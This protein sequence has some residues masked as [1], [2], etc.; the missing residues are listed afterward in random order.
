MS[1]YCDA[2]DANVKTAVISDTVY[3]NF[4]DKDQVQIETCRK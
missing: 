4:P 1:H 2:C 3:E